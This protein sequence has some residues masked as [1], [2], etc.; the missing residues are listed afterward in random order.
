[1]DTGKV[2]KSSTLK[3]WI[4]QKDFSLVQGNISVLVSFDQ[5]DL[6]ASA[7]NGDQLNMTITGTMK[8]HDFNVKAAITLPGDAQNAEDV[9]GQ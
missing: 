9:S 1:M 3:L 6:G 2:I 8:F 5:S 4:N 7:Q